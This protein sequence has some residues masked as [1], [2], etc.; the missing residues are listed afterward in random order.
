[1]AFDLSNYEDVATLN[2]WFQ[3]N[4]P[5]GRIAMDVISDDPKEERLIVLVSIYRDANDPHPAIQNI[6]RGKQGEYNRNLARFYA[7]DVATSAIGRAILL[8][9]G[10]DKTAHREGMERAADNLPNKFEKRIAEKIPVEKPSDP[11]TIEVKEMP[12]PV[13]EAVAALNDGITPEQ[14]PMCKHGPMT[15]KEGIGKTN[16][17]YH[18]YTCNVWSNDK[19]DPIWYEL[20]KSGRWIPQRPKVE[21]RELG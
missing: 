16:K 5:M 10:A 6:A 12:V 4:Y 2:R 15:L 11:W 20:D 7:E 19:C 1:M 9:K 14:V 13:N 3:E 18:G 21:T 8:L 17:P